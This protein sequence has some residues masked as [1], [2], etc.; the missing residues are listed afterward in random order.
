MRAP[1]T[2]TVAPSSTSPFPTWT[3]PPWM[4]VT[5]LGD[6]GGGPNWAAS[7]D[8]SVSRA[9]ALQTSERGRERNAS[10]ASFVMSESRPGASGAEERI[11]SALYGGEG[12]RQLRATLAA[13]L[14]IAAALLP[15]P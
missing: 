13:L 3:V 14:G 5:G 11:D 1:R 12:E 6:R 4:T 10:A 2:I 7:G 9:A 15:W 8:A